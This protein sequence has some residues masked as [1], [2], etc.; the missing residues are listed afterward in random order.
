MNL[1]AIIYRKLKR[2]DFCRNTQISLESNMSNNYKFSTFF[3]NNDNS[4]KVRFKPLSRIPRLPVVACMVVAIDIKGLVVLAKPKRGWGLPGGH[5]ENG[6]TAEQAAI[7]EVYEEAAVK[8]TNL[9]VAGGW[10]AEKIFD[11]ESNRHSPQK[12]YQLLFIAKI[13]KVDDFAGK[14]E[15]SER[16]F[17]PASELTDYIT[18]QS[19]AEI[20]RYLRSE[21]MI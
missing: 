18:S 3:W 2:L 10:L 11:T 7:R 17:V 8:I 19:F 13:E 6:E 1:F 14:F 16:A 15:T 4:T 9:R 5:L 21:H 20:H 12:S